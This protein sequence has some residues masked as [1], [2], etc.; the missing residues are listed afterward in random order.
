MTRIGRVRFQVSQ[1][2]DVRAPSDFHRGNWTDGPWNMDVETAP[3]QSYKNRERLARESTCS[4]Y[5]CIRQFPTSEITEWVDGGLTAL[6]PHCD[7]DALLPGA[8]AMDLLARMHERWF[9]AASL[10]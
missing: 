1:S 3:D 7:V 2:P 8:V 4:C 10:G 5:Q 6:C 9:C